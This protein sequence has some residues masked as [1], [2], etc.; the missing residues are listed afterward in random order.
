MALNGDPKTEL[1]HFLQKHCKRPVT[2]TDIVYQ[3][4]KFGPTQFQ[5]IVTIAC[6]NSQE[7]AS[8]VLPDQKA[9]EKSAAEQAL[10]ANADLVAEAMSLP[11]EKKRKA[12]APMMT[13]AERAAKKA[14]AE[15]AGVDN[16]AVTPK[17]TLNSLCMKIAKRFLHKGETVYETNKVAGQYQATVTLSCLPGDWGQ[18]AW[19]GHLSATKQKAEQSAA[20]EALKDIEADP[21]LSAEASTPKGKGK[22]KKG[23]DFGKGNPMLMGPG[24]MMGWDAGW[25]WGKGPKGWGKG[26]GKGGCGADQPRE[27]ITDAPILGTV[28]EW[29]GTF[30]WLQAAIPL[31]HPN[32]SAR[33]GKIYVHQKDL[34]AGLDSLLEGQA[35]GFHVYSDF[36]GLGADEVLSMA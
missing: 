29:K 20:E 10:A 32:A 12:A 35:V 17:T 8:E 3:V 6:L 28:M 21:E 25:G 23:K 1:N 30:G 7:Y 36:S 15:E 24:M 14:K 33:G 27:R 22:G 11:N 13:F 34:T 19:A 16:P 2:K 18:R 26:K 4:N 5:A 9:A 31:D